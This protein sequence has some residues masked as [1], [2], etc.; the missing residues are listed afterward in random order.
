MSLVPMKRIEIIA[1]Q[2]D[3]KKIVETLQRQGVVD[4]SD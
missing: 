1:L 3:A 4:I 2:R